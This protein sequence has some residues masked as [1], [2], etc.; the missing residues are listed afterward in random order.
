MITLDK[1]ELW[2]EE[3]APNLEQN[4][5]WQQHKTREHREFDQ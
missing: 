1:P 5:H 2:D 4:L 3:E